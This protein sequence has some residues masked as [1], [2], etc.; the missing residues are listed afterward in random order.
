VPSNSVPQWIARA[1]TALPYPKIGG[2]S[3][4]RGPPEDGARRRT[5]SCHD[6]AR[7]CRRFY[8]LAGSK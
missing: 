6:V 5:S 3:R 7:L 8:F 2:A 1:V 4:R